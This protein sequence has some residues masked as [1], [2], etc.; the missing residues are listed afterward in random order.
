MRAAV[1]DCGVE[2]IGSVMRVPEELHYTPVLMMT[3]AIAMQAAGI[4]VRRNFID[5][6]K[7]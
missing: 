2:N 3:F 5:S 1:I 6:E 4:P 7:K